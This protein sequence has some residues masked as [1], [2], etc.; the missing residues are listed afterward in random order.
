MERQMQYGALRPNSEEM[1]REQRRRRYALA[2]NEARH[3]RTGLFTVMMLADWAIAMA[4]RTEPNRLVRYQRRHIL[5]NTWR[6][7]TGD[8]VR[9]TQL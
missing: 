1:A 7:L 8:L 4:A 2:F 5:Q 9:Q 3:S 6:R